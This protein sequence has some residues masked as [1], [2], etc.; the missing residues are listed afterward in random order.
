MASCYGLG[1]ILIVEA[2]RF[3]LGSEL[4]DECLELRAVV[5]HPG[6][7]QFCGQLYQAF[8]ALGLMSYF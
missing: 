1:R 6:L 3:Y 7:L 5:S 2:L 4:C 8:M